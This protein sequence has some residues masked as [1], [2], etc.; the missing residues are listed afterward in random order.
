MGI[1]VRQI[2]SSQG[3]LG[4]ARSGR[5]AA[6]VLAC[7]TLLL[8]GCG[9]LTP[10]NTPGRAPSPVVAVSTFVPTRRPEASSASTQLPSEVPT[11]PIEP[12]AQPPGS[13]LCTAPSS[14]TSLYCATKN[15]DGAHGGAPL[16]DLPSAIAMDYW[17]R[18]RCTFTLGLST[19]QSSA[20]LPSLT[21]T[22][23]GPEVD[24]TWRASIRPGKYYPVIGEAV[25]CVYSVNVR[26]DR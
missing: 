2:S 5:T 1:R 7:S 18:G 17:V 20:G 9:V 14:P 23:S 25:G 12:T 16:L 26:A 24:G 3:S 13:D 22:V 21:V 19:L 6:A 10:L 11:Q 8:G 15:A 4:Q